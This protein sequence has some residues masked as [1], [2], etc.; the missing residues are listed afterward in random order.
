[1]KIG[2]VKEIKPEEH[3]VG[4]TPNG[5]SVLIARGHQVF[6]EQAAGVGSGFSDQLYRQ[7]GATIVDAEQAWANDLV[8]KVKEPIEPEYSRLKQQIIFTY[9]HLAGVPRALTESLLGEGTTAVAYETLEDASGRLPLLAPMSAIAGN[10]SAQ[11]GC[12]YLAKCNGGKGVM[13]GS[14]LGK[15]HGKV[16]VI[17]DGVVGSHAARTAFGLG[18]N[19]VVAGIFP[20]NAIRLQREISPEIDFIISEPIAI[21]EQVSTADL[22]IGAVLTPGARAA[23]VVTADMVRSMQPG[24]VIV[25]VSIDQ[26]G[27]VETAH[28]T[29]HTHPVFEKYGVLHYCVSNMPGAYP[30]TA[31]LALTDATLP[32]LLE[33]ADQ[34]LSALSNDQGFAKALNTHQGYITCKPVAAALSMLESYRSYPNQF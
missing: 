30:R 6:V 23:H 5:V 24:S 14:V 29:T 20:E 1:M 4:L 11:M 10:M 33:L 31:T 22:V 8:V 28:A 18:A 34:G 15:R 2:L 19:V 27:C 25:D 32:Y 12:H 16:L 17:G 21:A 9:F 7:A 26:G 3:R 13:L